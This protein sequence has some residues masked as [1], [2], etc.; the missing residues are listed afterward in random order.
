M[1]VANPSFWLAQVLGSWE[2]YEPSKHFDGLVAFHFSSALS[3]T[4][5]GVRWLVATLAA[6]A[7]FGRS[8]GNV[9]NGNVLT[10][11]MKRQKRDPN[12]SNDPIAIGMNA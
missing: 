9:G 7:A 3:K 8:T 6:L 12:P 4:F 10:L 11:S 5:S 2:R 1:I